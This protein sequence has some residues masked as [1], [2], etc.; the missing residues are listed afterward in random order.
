MR[1]EEK[2]TVPTHPHRQSPERLEDDDCFQTV[3]PLEERHCKEEVV[4]SVFP[5]F[6]LKVQKNV[7]SFFLCF[8]LLVVVL[9]I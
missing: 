9:G 1:Q 6:F 7:V 3:G 2:D 4:E 8:L 5:F